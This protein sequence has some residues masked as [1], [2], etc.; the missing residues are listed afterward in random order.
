[1]AQFDLDWSMTG[2]A[3]IEADDSDEAEQILTEGLANLDSSMFDSVD[4]H[5]VTSESCAE[6]DDDG[7]SP[8]C[9]PDISERLRHGGAA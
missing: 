4:V 3:V 5:E 8:L 9:V 6:V 2:S 1:M 7:A